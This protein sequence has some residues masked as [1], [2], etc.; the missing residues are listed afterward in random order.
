[1]EGPF[2]SSGCGVD[3]KTGAASLL[4]NVDHRFLLQNVDAMMIILKVR[5]TMPHAW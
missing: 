1:M 3:K 5:C 2:F 4:Q